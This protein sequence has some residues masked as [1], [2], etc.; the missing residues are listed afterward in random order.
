M[1]HTAKL[2]RRGADKRAQRADYR[3]RARPVTSS[4]RDHRDRL[5]NPQGPSRQ[6]RRARRFRD[7]PDHARVART[8]AT[9]AVV[10]ARVGSSEEVP[11]HGGTTNAGLVT[12]VGDTVRRP[13]R[14][15]S[16]ATRALLDH[17]ERVGFEGAPRYLGVDDRGREVLSYIPGQAAIPAYPDWAMT[18]EALISVAQLMRRY[19]DAV[20]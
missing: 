1:R 15:T 13:L 16:A 19:H 9:R 17:L 6:G 7:Q 4:T 20:A 8:R 10:R 3:D 11:L 5:R 2:R 14:P 12:R 18:G